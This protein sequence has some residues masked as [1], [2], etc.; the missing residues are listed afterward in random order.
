[1]FGNQVPL[2]GHSQPCDTTRRSGRTYARPVARLFMLGVAAALTLSISAAC[3]DSSTESK[4][5][6]SA[7]AARTTTAPAGGGSGAATDGGGSTE[8]TVIMKDNVYEPKTITV[9]VNKEIEFKVKNQ[10]QAIHN[11]H[12]L[13]KAA[14]GQDFQSATIV[15]PGADN[16]FKAKFTKAGTYNFQCDFHLP[17]M[18]GTITVK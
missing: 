7:P 6:T 4:P 17:D 14:E 15:N 12:I 8:V 9:P 2:G 10:G 13:S 5:A 16:E 18:A 1:M 11:M 3:S